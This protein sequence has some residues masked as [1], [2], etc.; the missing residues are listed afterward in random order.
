MAACR[1]RFAGS[2]SSLRDNRPR[3]VSVTYAAVAHT[4][5]LLFDKV[6]NAATFAAGA[7]IINVDGALGKS[8]SSTV[9]AGGSAT[10]VLAAP[11]GPLEV[12]T[13]TSAATSNPTPFKSGGSIGAPQWA[14]VP[15]ILV[16]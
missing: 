2:T 5:T 11:F 3:I 13:T 7:V 14:N 15:V 10:V 8:S 6:I 12:G 16:A 4:I 9:F 1:P